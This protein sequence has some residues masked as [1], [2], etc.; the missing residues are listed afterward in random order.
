MHEC[1]YTLSVIRDLMYSGAS[2][3]MIYLKMLSVALYS[4]KWY[5]VKWIAK[6]MET[7]GHGLT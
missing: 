2:F 4:I 1:V 3:F 5:D 6:E 7:D